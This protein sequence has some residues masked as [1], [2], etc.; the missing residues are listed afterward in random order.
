LF[1]FA[2]PARCGWVKG[3]REMALA[4]RGLV[5][6]LCGFVASLLTIASTRVFACDDPQTPQQ[7]QSPASAAAS[8]PNSQTQPK[9][10]QTPSSQKKKKDDR[11][12]FVMP[13]FL[14]V[15]NEADVEPL[16][17]QQKFAITA[18]GV[19]DPYEFGVVGILAGIRQSE[20]A[21]PAFGQG[22]AGYSKRYGTA[23]ADQVDGNMMVGAVFP[24]ILKTDPRYFQLG[25]GRFFHRV[26]YAIS[27]VFVTRKDSGGHTFNVAESLGNGVAIGIA[28]FYYPAS[29]RGVTSSANDWGV[30]MG[31]DA[32]GN[33]LKEFWPDIHRHFARK[34]GRNSPN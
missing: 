27:R 16:R 25:Q 10:S 30:Q 34:K 15:E 4:R 33:E 12:F 2:G 11:V 14:T 17:W 1:A 20:N 32:I 6:L 7:A 23:L 22:V 28:N 5:L 21:Y 8:A 3:N 19:F 26:G 24:S 18:R 9:Q 31:I 13:N 29:D